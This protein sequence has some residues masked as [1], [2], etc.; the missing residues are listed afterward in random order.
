MLGTYRQ[1]E[2][3][4]N[5]ADRISALDYVKNTGFVS[6]VAP[7]DVRI[8]RFSPLRGRTQNGDWP[9]LHLEDPARA[10]RCP[11]EPL[12]TLRSNR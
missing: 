3:A 6:S 1:G 10:N 12:E 8:T 5:V 2:S 7:A 4:Q 9:Q 11:H